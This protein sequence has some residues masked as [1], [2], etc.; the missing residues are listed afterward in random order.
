MHSLTSELDGGER[1]GKEEEPNTL[2]STL[3]LNILNLCYSLSVRETKFYT[4]IKHEVNALLKFYCSSLKPNSGMKLAGRH[5]ICYFPPSEQ[6]KLQFDTAA[7]MKHFL[8]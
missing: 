1:S 2:L 4:H 3:F 7:S 6:Q 5:K 8:N